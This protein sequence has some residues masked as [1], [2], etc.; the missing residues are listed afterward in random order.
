MKWIVLSGLTILTLCFLVGCEPEK[1]EGG[2]NLPERGVEIVA[3]FIK[4]ERSDESGGRIVYVENAPEVEPGERQWCVN[5]RFVNSRGLSTIPLLIRQ[6]GE[7]WRLE[8]NPDRA[9]YE[10]YGCVWP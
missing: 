8:R 4:T 2:G 10:G 7:E 9:V 3:N 1:R 5:V 6:R